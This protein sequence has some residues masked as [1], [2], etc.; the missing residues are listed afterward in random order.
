M[1]S[2]TIAALRTFLLAVLPSGTEVVL[3][4]DNRVPEPAADDFC[5]MTITLRERLATNTVTTSDSG[6]AGPGL[7]MAMAPTRV[8]VQVD[9][10]GPSSSDNAQI[11]STL[12]RDSFGADIF[13]ATGLNVAP[14]YCGDP[15]QLPFINGE[16]QVEMRWSIDAVMQANPVVTT[17]QDF[18]GA[19]QVGLL[20]VD[21]TY[22]PA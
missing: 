18:A 22:P 11:I 6:P 5:V 3:G 10:H 8:T 1:S 12:F 16:Q 9:V 13:A 21:A 7:R 2:Q 4:Q 17:G 14:L 20:Q 19:L 15:R